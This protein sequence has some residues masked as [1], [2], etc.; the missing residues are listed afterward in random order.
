MI[1]DCAILNSGT[2][3][4]DKIYEAG[5]LTY[6]D[7]NDINPYQ[8]TVTKLIVKGDQL[9]EALEQGI[10]QYPALEGRFPQVSRIEFEFDPSKE[11]MSRIVPGSLKILGKPIN[12]DFHYTVAVPTYLANGKDGYTVLKN[13]PSLIDPD[14]ER[15]LTE[16]LTQFFDLSNRE[17]YTEEYLTYLNH[18]TDLTNQSIRQLISQKQEDVEIAKSNFKKILFFSFIYFYNISLIFFYIKK[19]IK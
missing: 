1:S 19:L 12:L 15:N 13:C 11:P 9:Q 4:A 17:K 5:P 2:L 8:K 3:R 14:S 7:I 6:G 10:S 16:I 18:K